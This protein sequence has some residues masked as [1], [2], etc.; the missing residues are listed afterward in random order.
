M[1]SIPIRLKPGDDVRKTLELMAIENKW[2]SAFVV[3]GIGSLSTAS[4]RMAGVSESTVMKDVDLEVLTLCGS[5]S[6]LVGGAHL[7]ITVSDASGKVVGGH[8]TN[9]CIV[10]TTAELLINVMPD[11]RFER[12]VDEVTGF[13][14]LFPVRIREEKE[15]A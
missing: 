5:I 6:P 1:Q 3:A 4:I 9:G 14:E 10:R 15:S 11:W 13:P 7:H 2:S 12:R 8:V